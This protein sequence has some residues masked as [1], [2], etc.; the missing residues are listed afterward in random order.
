[1]QVSDCPQSVGVTAG[2]RSELRTAG[3]IE[4][5]SALDDDASSDLAHDI[6]RETGIFVRI[7]NGP[8]NAERAPEELE[9]EVF[10][11]Y[12]QKIAKDDGVND[13]VSSRRGQSH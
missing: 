5:S 3:S 8:R 6:L 12:K 13:S 1:V 4:G 9:Q 2:L 10:S 7:E 11:P